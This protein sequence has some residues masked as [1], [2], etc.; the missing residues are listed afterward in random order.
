MA[1]ERQFFGKTK[2]ID[3]EKHNIIEW[4]SE[5]GSVGYIT[6]Q[7]KFKKQTTDKTFEAIMVGYANHHARDTYK[8]YKLETKIF[9]MDRDVKW[10]NWKISNPA[11]TLNIFC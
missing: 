2:K 10:V 7:D 5:F 4:L 11:E 6:N 8:L 9:I 3:E 1:T